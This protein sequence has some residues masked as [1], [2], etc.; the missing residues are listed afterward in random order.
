[1]KISLFQL[2]PILR[3]KFIRVQGWDSRF[4]REVKG[5][6]FPCF[7]QYKKIF[8]SAFPATGI[9][10]LRFGYFHQKNTINCSRGTADEPNHIEAV[11]LAQQDCS[12]FGLGEPAAGVQSKA[13]QFQNR[14]NALHIL[15]EK[16]GTVQHPV[17][18]LAD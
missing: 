12:Q 14:L 11:S 6:F 5:H 1:M 8:C 18:K 10:K 7:V 17:S 9:K 13:R 16:T 2:L 4:G 3:E 15:L